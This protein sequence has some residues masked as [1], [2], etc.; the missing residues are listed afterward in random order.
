MVRVCGGHGDAD[1]MVRI[2]TSDLIERDKIAGDL[3]WLKDNNW[4]EPNRLH[5]PDK[6]DITTWYWFAIS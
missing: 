6:E 5:M 2:T 4:I 1:Y 3:K